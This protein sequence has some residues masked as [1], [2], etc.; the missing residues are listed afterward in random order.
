M[1]S[2]Q[3]NIIQKTSS[4]RGPPEQASLDLL[5]VWTL[6]WWTTDRLLQKVA[7][8][9]WWVARQVLGDKAWAGSACKTCLETTSVW[10][11]QIDSSTVH[12][13]YW[14]KKAYPENGWVKKKKI[15][16]DMYFKSRASKLE[17]IY[18]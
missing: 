6:D 5:R 14:I 10:E 1:I 9:Y 7:I 13:N 8:G 4:H 12:F 11:N 2:D 18:K 3:L 17:K 15:L 16:Q